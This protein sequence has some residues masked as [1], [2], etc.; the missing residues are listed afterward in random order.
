[1]KLFMLLYRV[2]ASVLQVANYN[3]SKPYKSPVTSLVIPKA[4]TK[5][6]RHWERETPLGNNT[7]PDSL[8]IGPRQLVILFFNSVRKQFDIYIYICTYV[9]V[10]SYIYMYIVYLFF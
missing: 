9:Y 7:E 3:P 5:A 1:M 10:M 6:L 2:S 4:N 8:N